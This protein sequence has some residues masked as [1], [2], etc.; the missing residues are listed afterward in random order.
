MNRYKT[1]ISKTYDTIFFDTKC[2]W[3]HF[4]KI[5]NYIGFVYC[6]RIDTNF[7]P[8]AQIFDH[9]IKNC[10]V[11]F[12]TNV[13][14]I[15]KCDCFPWYITDFGPLKSEIMNVEG[16]TLVLPSCFSCLTN[17]RE[18]ISYKLEYQLCETRSIRTS[19][20]ITLKRKRTSFLP[21]SFEHKKVTWHTPAIW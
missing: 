11:F 21:P 19:T 16:A 15:S 7:L 1:D 10:K 13:L 4:E 20:S 6:Y 5:S 3:C 8:I 2:N 17:I 18:N 9:W 12:L 14:K